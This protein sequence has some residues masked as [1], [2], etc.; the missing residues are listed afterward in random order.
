MRW[1]TLSGE[2]IKDIHQWIKDNTDNTKDVHI[3]TDSLNTGRFTQFVT[4][5]IIYTPTKG[6]R[7]AYTRDVVPRMTSLRERLVKEVWRSVTL[8]LEL[9]QTIQG[10]MSI[11]VDANTKE[12]YASSKYVQELVGLVVGQGFS[13]VLKPDSWAACHAADHIVRTRGKLPK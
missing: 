2:K 5:V 7:V 6:G 11:H 9:D 1:R 4:V 13:V 10:R 12:R 3:G 8:G